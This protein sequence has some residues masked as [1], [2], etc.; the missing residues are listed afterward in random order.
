MTIVLNLFFYLSFYIKK[1]YV[2]TRYHFLRGG[3]SIEAKAKKQ[4]L[5]TKH[6]SEAEL[7]ALSGMS[8]LVIRL[9]EFLVAQGYKLNSRLSSPSTDVH[10][11]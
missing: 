11:I 2:S 6:S 8:S 7:V 10:L 1:P 3:G 5:V 4:S 9:R